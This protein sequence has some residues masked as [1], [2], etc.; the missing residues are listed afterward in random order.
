MI[1]SFTFDQDD[2]IRLALAEAVKTL[3]GA[4]KSSDLEASVQFSGGS[5]VSDYQPSDPLRFKI[6]VTELPPGSRPRP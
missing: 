3:G 4:F 1:R 6:V 2:L 5:N